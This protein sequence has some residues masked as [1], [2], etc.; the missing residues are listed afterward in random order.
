M[1]VSA[2]GVIGWCCEGVSPRVTVANFLLLW[3][4]IQDSNLA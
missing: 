4:G 1:S 3:L 2:M